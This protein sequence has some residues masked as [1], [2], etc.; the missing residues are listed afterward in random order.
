MPAYVCLSAWLRCTGVAD[1]TLRPVMCVK[2]DQLSFLV[3]TLSPVFVSLHCM[4]ALAIHCTA[5]KLTADGLCLAHDLHF[6][7]FCL[8]GACSTFGG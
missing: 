8:A 6:F 4:R 7:F 3:S 2:L 5:D 1:H